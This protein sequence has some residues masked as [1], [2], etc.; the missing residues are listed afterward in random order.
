MNRRK[1]V[2]KQPLQS[3]QEFAVF[4]KRVREESGVSG[5]E[6]AEGLMDT[7]QLSRIENEIRSVPKT[8]RDRL[9]GR[10]GVTPDMYEN[11]LG[12]E[13][14]AEW[15]WQRKILCA[16][17]RRDFQE[18]ECLIREYEMQGAADRTKYQFCIMMRA[19]LLKLQGAGRAELAGFYEEAVRMTVPESERVYVQPKLLS[20]LEVNMMLEYECYRESK[21]G[22]GDKCRFWAEYVKDSLYDEL[23]MAKILPKIVY[24][25]LREILTNEHAMALGE[26]QQ[27]LLLCDDVIEL[28]RNTGR[29]FY[30]VELLEYNE[31]DIDQYRQ[32]VYRKRETAGGS[33]VSDSI[34]GQRRAGKTAEKA[35]CGVWRAGLYAGLYIP[36]PAALDVR[37]WRCP[38]HPQNHAWTDAGGAV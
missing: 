25:Y 23:S 30:L 22:F 10:L 6:L 36:V 20:A 7:S 4:L 5:E 11:L 3:E 31:E 14:Y 16:I 17:A 15:E 33:G 8:M 29:A 9:L 21:S 27:A 32:T 2:L 38:V 19:E 35:L 37:D 1:N 34:E 18:S 13:D 28:L 12:N 26:L 24:Y